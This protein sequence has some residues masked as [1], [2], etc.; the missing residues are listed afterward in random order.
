[1]AKAAN[2][3]EASSRLVGNDKC[4]MSWIL[5]NIRALFW[6]ASLAVRCVGASKLGNCTW[7]WAKR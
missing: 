1:M 6:G 7:R 2:N 4:S 3:R 5:V